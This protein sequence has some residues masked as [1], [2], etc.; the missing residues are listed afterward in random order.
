[1]KKILILMMFLI[2]NGSVF[3]SGQKEMYIDF[4]QNNVITDGRLNGTW[5]QK[6]NSGGVSWTAIYTFN[7]SEF[8]YEIH[9]TN[10]KYPFQT[11]HGNFIL[12]STH[13]H[14]DAIE[15]ETWP[16]SH[17]I[18]KWSQ[19]YKLSGDILELDQTNPYRFQNGKFIKQ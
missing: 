3:G 2:A 18:T 14:F 8:L 9:S 1:M 4:D 10:P 11:Y 7:G 16:Y 5:V 19:G 6:G 15:D 17:S 12:T 13:I